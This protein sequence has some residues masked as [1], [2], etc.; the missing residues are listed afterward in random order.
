MAKTAVITGGSGGIG[1][2]CAQALKVRGYDVV[3]T[4]RTEK[5]LREAA[6][7]VGARWVAADSAEPEEFSRVLAG[8]ESVELLI[9]SAGVLDGTFVRKEAVET[10]DAV[11]RGNLRSSFVVCNAVI[12]LMPVGG[13]IVLISSSS[14]K[15]PMKGRAAYSAS[16]AGVNAFASAL[17]DEVARDGINVNVLIPAPVETAMLEGVS[18]GMHMIQARDV[19]DAVVFLD[20]LDPTVIV[21][22]IY[23]EAHSSG[24]LAPKLSEHGS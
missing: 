2:A 20:A 23:M 19:A 5:T 15:Y 13:R 3:L 17:R 10:W 8:L 21:P 24:P 9:H 16:K 6:E 22:E 18:F 4:A 11:V 14:S 12:P 1:L 7:G